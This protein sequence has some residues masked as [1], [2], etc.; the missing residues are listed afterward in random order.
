MG[1]FRTLDIGRGGCFRRKLLN[2][3]Q[4]LSISMRK[5][6]LVLQPVT[7]RGVEPV[8]KADDFVDVGPGAAASF[9]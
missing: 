8:P 2:S 3:P 9:I 1:D 7:N 6:K 5:V 4:I